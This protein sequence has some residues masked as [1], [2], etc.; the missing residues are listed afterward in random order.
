MTISLLR[1]NLQRSWRNKKQ[2]FV[3]Y[4]K[5][6]SKGSTKNHVAFQITRGEFKLVF[7]FKRCND[8]VI[9]SHLAKTNLLF[10]NLVNITIRQ[11][12]LQNMHTLKEFSCQRISKTAVCSSH[13]HYQCLCFE[14][15]CALPKEIS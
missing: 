5:T 10:C 15:L 7:A 2:N 6:N 9:C 12:A 11:L 8:G 1:S 4:N 3:G 14:C 13:P